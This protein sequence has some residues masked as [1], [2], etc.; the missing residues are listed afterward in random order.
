MVKNIKTLLSLMVVMAAFFAVALVLSNSAFAIDPPAGETEFPRSDYGVIVDMN[1]E[2]PGNFAS[3][4]GHFCSRNGTIKVGGSSTTTRLPD[5]APGCGTW[6]VLSPNGTIDCGRDAFLGDARATAINKSDNC[7]TYNEDTIN[8]IHCPDSPLFPSFSVG[9]A[10]VI[11]NGA[12]IFPDNYSDLII[13]K[14]SICNFKEPGTY[15][16]RRIITGDGSRLLFESPTGTCDPSAPFRIN[17]KDFVLISEFVIFNPDNIGPVYV[18]VEGNDGFYDDGTSSANTC[19][20]GLDGLGP[21]AFCDKGDGILN[22]C[23][24]NAINGTC[25]LRGS[26]QSLGQFFCKHF[27]QAIGLPVTTQLPDECCCDTSGTIN[28]I[29]DNGTTNDPT[30]ELILSSTCA[31]EMCFALTMEDL[32]VA[33]CVPY[34]T[35]YSEFDISPGGNGPKTVWV[36]FRNKFGNTEPISDNTIYSDNIFFPAPDVSSDQGS[37]TSEIRPTWRWSSNQGLVK[38]QSFARQDV[39]LQLYHVMPKRYFLPSLL[40]AVFQWQNYGDSP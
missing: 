32:N 4:T 10:D 36:Q 21:S 31:E 27:R 17:V 38:V 13:G 39:A 35:S 23:Y 25:S 37:I 28:I 30:P 24:V 1:M 40:S 2:I 29:D 15:N 7:A 18:N 8:L 34:N 16:F 12:D 33:D 22:M 14:N 19:P 3:I 5:C 6:N 11:C 9:T 20:G 26:L